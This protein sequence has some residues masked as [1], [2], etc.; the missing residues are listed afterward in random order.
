MKLRVVLGVFFAGMLMG[1]LLH[2]SGLWGNKTFFSPRS[3]GADSARELVGRSQAFEMITSGSASWTL[4]MAPVYIHSFNNEHIV[5]YFFSHNC[6][7]GSGSRVPVGRGACDIFT[8]YF[9]LPA[10]FSTRI[11]FSPVRTSF[12]FDVDLYWQMP[13][14]CDRLF[15]KVHFPIEHAKFDLRLSEGMI[16]PAPAPAFQPAGYLGEQAITDYTRRSLPDDLEDA[17]EGGDFQVGDIDQWYRYGNIWGREYHSGIADLRTTLGVCVVKRDNAHLGIG[18]CVGFP[19]GTRPDAG[20]LYEAIVGNGHHWQLGAEILG[21]WHFWQPDTTCWNA[22]LYWQ[23]CVTHLFASCQNRSYD[24]KC[25]PGSRYTLLEEFRVGSQGLF[26]DNA[27]SVPAPYQYNQ[28]LYPAINLTT[29]RSH[30][31][32][33]VQADASIMFAVQRAG[34]ELDLGYNFWVRSVEKL[35]CRDKF[36]TGHGNLYAFKGDAQVYGF[37]VVGTST[38][39]V[40][41][42]ATQHCATLHGGQG[43]GNFVAGHEYANAN[44]DSPVPAFMAGGVPL[45]Q[46]NNADSAALGIA[47]QQVNTSSSPLFLSDTDINEASALMARSFTNKIFAHVGYTWRED[48]CV[49]PYFGAGADI[50]WG[51]GCNAIFDQ[52]GIWI[53]GGLVY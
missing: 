5:D 41:L 3:Q 34:L 26:L 21:S 39:A 9:A 30:I 35:T 22:G 51:P 15:F 42:S 6:L 52:G 53:K 31:K 32:V 28:T 43:D 48:A 45:Q 11:G 38:V 24:F 16:T 29:L 44:A 12:I 17:L 14:A 10:N 20:F 7:A 25:N 8:D 4:S 33:D 18:L 2:A 13:F 36:A 40:P 49:V 50:E 46:L 37:A 23:A 19:T 27:G 47:Q 1:P